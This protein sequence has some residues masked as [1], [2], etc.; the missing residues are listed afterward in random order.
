MLL[1]RDR[2]CKE[3]FLCEVMASPTLETQPHIVAIVT[4]VGGGEI[5]HERLDMNSAAFRKFDILWVKLALV[6][7]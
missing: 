7:K 6:Q 1:S 5:F 2:G 4:N 3:T